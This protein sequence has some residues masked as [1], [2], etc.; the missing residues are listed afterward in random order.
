L[1]AGKVTIRKAGC[2]S[3]AGF[4]HV[5]IKLTLDGSIERAASI[6]NREIEMK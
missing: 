6:M 2:F 5:L 1:N 3:A 4:L